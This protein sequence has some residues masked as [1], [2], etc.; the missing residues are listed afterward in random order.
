M[1]NENKDGVK[2]CLFFVVLIFI[3][4]AILAYC[5]ENKKDTNKEEVEK[6]S[7]GRKLETIDTKGYI[8][9][10]DPRVLSANSLLKDVAYNFKEPVDSIAEHTQKLQGVLHDKG[11]DV[12]CLEI[13]KVMR[14]A[15][16]SLYKNYQDACFLY[17]LVSDQTN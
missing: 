8:T 3:I 13:L 6:M 9:E 1:T 7:I 11:I 16:R 5:G 4:S 12:S 14:K 17:Y 2:G 10:D 15:N